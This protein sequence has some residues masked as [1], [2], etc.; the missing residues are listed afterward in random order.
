MFYKLLITLFFLT[1]T[2]SFAAIDC[3]EEIHKL[4]QN[5]KS[6]SGK[7]LKEKQHLLPLSCQSELNTLNNVAAD[8]TA[9]CMQDL[10]K[11]C[12]VNMKVLEKSVETAMLRQSEC[13]KKMKSQFSPKCSSLI[14]NM[15]KAFT[16]KGGPGAK[17]IR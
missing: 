5:A 13:I 7:C 3:E 9:N 6:G 1:S 14:E 15:T 12:P 16:G 17:T 4:C 11:F 2:A 8:V 10:M